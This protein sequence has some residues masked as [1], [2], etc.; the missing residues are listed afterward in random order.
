MPFEYTFLDGAKS[1]GFG[2]NQQQMFGSGFYLATPEIY[3]LHRRQDVDASRE[4]LLHQYL[5]DMLGG[6]PVGAGSHDDLMRRGFY[7]FH[8]LSVSFCALGDLE[9]APVRMR[10]LG[11]F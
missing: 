11:S 2:L 3:R 8:Y 4:T 10:G 7:G 9:C 6:I 5:G 1:A